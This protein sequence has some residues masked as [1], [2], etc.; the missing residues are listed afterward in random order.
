ML[1][2]ELLNLKFKRESKMKNLLN[3]NAIREAAYYIWKNN[4]CQANTSLNDWNAAIAQ[5]NAMASL[6]NG[7]KKS[8]SLKSLSSS[9]KTS[10]KSAAAA[11]KSSAASLSKKLTKTTSKKSK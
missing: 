10:V 3:E 4:G 7:S 8:T 2:S 11:L 5:L 9:K 1:Y 6:S